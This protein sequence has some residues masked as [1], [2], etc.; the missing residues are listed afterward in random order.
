MVIYRS[1]PILDRR[2]GIHRPLLSFATSLLK[3]ARVETRVPR[4]VFKPILK[5]NPPWE[6]DKRLHILE[7]DNRGEA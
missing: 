7:I 4:F 1:M 5:P 2:F 3:L 6:K